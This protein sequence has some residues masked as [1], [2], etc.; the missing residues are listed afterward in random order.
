MFLLP[1]DEVQIKRVIRFIKTGRTDFFESYSALAH[2]ATIQPLF[3][4]IFIQVET[5]RR[6]SPES[7]PTG[8]SVAS[9][10]TLRR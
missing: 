2:Y 7:M 6:S 9:C 5:D 10:S 4:V 3:L 8:L 1:Q